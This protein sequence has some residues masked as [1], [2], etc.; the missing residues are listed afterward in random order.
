M[1]GRS[2]CE[3]FQSR[4]RIAV[5]LLVCAFCL[6]IEGGDA[7]SANTPAQLG[8]A[9]IPTEKDRARH[10]D[11]KRLRDQLIKGGGTELVFIGD[12]IFDH[13]RENPQREIFDHYFGKYRPYNIGISGDETQHVLWRIE[14]G[15]LDGI[16][17]RVT[18]ILI[19]TN[20]LGNSHMSPN[21]T[22]E[23][24]N[25]LVRTVGQT[26]PDTTILLLGVLPRGNRSDDPFRHLITLTNTMIVDGRRIKYL[27]IGFKFLDSD[28]NL[29]AEVMY[30]YLHP[31]ERGYEILAEALAP[32]VDDLEKE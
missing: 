2:S 1:A 24:I 5:A 7:G 22:A 9:C 23:G 15:E 18:V 31:T 12:S 10:E 8:H 28:G 29:H 27:D 19:G 3:Y 21:E 25:C 16:R 26:L 20:N 13:W 11:F 32:T 6:G 14:H 17:P 30:D 4:I